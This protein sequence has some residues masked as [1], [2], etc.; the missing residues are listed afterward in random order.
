MSVIEI[1]LFPVLSK[2]TAPVNSLSWVRVITPAPLLN[3]AAPAEAVCV[4]A[5]VCVMPTA[6]TVKVPVPTDDV[7]RMMALASAT[8]TP[9][10][11]LLF[12]PT[13]PVKSLRLPSE[14][15]PPAV[16]E[17]VPRTVKIPPND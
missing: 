14:M 6:L 9:F 11:P 8:A 7:P 12:R 5:P 17:E 10:A 3:V 13:A 16:K 2:L 4:I 15:A 1:A